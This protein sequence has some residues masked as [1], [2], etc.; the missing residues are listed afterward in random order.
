MFRS[1]RFLE[2]PEKVLEAWG[3]AKCSPRVAKKDRSILFRGPR[4]AQIG[5]SV[6]KVAFGKG[7][8]C[9]NSNITGDR[10]KK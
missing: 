10:S 9:K 3:V 7:G 2:G 8:A 1:E 5:T 4:E 6:E